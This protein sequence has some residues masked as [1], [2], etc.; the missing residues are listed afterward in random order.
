MSAYITEV[1]AGTGQLDYELYLAHLS[2]MKWPRP[3][4]IEHLPYEEY[5]IAQKNIE[6]TAARIGVKFHGRA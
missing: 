2:H 6:D 4:L 3:L 1:A 5:D